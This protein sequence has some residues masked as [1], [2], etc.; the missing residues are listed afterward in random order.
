MPSA[1][2]EPSF[3]LA[4][5]SCIQY[6]PEVRRSRDEAERI[7]ILDVCKRIRKRGFYGGI[8]LYALSHR[9]SGH[10]HVVIAAEEDDE[11]FICKCCKEAQ[12]LIRAREGPLRYKVCNCRDCVA[13]DRKIRFDME[14]ITRS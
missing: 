11:K 10:V 12:K 14:Q 1:K 7:A 13:C 4:E 3:S 5:V 8:M 6:E 9:K 2:K